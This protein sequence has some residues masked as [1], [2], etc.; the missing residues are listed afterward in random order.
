MALATGALPAPSPR[1][2]TT[3]AGR[4]R[5]SPSLAG[6]PSPIAGDGP[7]PPSPATGSGRRRPSAPSLP[8]PPPSLSAHPRRRRIWSG[9]RPAPPPFLP[10]QAAGSG[11]ATAA[12]PL[13][14]L[15]RCPELG[16]RACGRA[17]ASSAAG[18][19]AAAAGGG[20]TTRG[21]LPSSSGA[22]PWR[23]G[24]ARG[25][26]VGC[27]RSPAAGWAQAGPWPQPPAVAARRRRGCRAGDGA[28]PLW[29]SGR[30]WLPAV[31]AA[32]R[33]EKE[34]KEMRRIYI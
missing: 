32:W 23:S 29:T 11:G 19:G 12:P 7:P 21:V 34:V 18:G 8:Q 30:E 17:C 20:H 6:A 28:A 15:R 31:G 24:A 22:H 16:A 9:A 10:W 27:G 2:G 4:R 33:I 25:R 26:P 3:R 5:S 14:S 1:G 13:C